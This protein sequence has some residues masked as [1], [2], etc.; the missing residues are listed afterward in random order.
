MRLVSLPPLYEGSEE[1]EG[2]KKKR[3]NVYGERIA[4]LKKTITPADGPPRRSKPDGC[5]EVS[6]SC[7]PLI[8][9]PAFM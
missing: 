1:E 3:V 4:A 6:K 8:T 2:G 5:W 7:R 9:S